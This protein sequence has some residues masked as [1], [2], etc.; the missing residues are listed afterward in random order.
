MKN[1]YLVL[2]ILL[3]ASCASKDQID[4]RQVKSLI[5]PVHPTPPKERRMN[6]NNE[7]VYSFVDSDGNQYVIEWEDLDSIKYNGKKFD[8]TIGQCSALIGAH[9]PKTLSEPFVI[10][11][12]LIFKQVAQCFM[13]SGYKLIRSNAYRPEVVVVALS[14]RYFSGGEIVGDGGRIEIDSSGLVMKEILPKAKECYLLS[15][16]KYSQGGAGSFIYI[17]MKPVID[18]FEICLNNKGLKV[19]TVKKKHNKLLKYE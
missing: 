18:A 19:K 3:M 4:S 14:K 12:P 9:Y 11:Q 10:D 1:I 6:Y 2:S 13:S 5:F 8:A 16:N 15:K 7:Y 17:D